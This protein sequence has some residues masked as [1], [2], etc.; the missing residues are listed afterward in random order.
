MVKKN[1][2]YFI[3]YVYDDYK[4]K[5]LYIMLP[6]TSTY[7]KRYDEQTKLI[8][9]LSVDN[10]LLEKYNTIWDKVGADINKFDSKSV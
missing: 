4:V 2:K 5:P 7:V 1:Y 6:K 9:F 8:F 3:V 10:D